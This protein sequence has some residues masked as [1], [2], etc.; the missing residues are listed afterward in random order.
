MPV[1]L[2]TIRLDALLLKQNDLPPDVQGGQVRRSGP[3]KLAGLPRAAQIVWQEFIISGKYLSDGI[4]IFLYEGSADL[5][6]A[7]A[8]VTED[9]TRD[10]EKLMPVAGVGEIARLSETIIRAQV[11]IMGA[12]S[13][14]EGRSATVIFVR[15]H[16]LVYIHLFARPASTDLATAD[17]ASKYA[18]RI[19]KKLAEYVC[20]Q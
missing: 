4:A 18:Q 6:K 2:S 12:R 3:P 9:M 5:C 8:K 7:Y 19:D 16:A 15:C 14:T 20:P 17:V 10:G 1:P 11:N 13:V